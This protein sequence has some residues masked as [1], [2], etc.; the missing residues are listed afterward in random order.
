MNKSVRDILI[1]SSL[2]RT[3]EYDGNII[4]D[5]KV[6]ECI[7]DMYFYMLYFINNDSKKEEYFREFESKYQKL[8]KKQQEIVRDEYIDIIKTQKKNKE[9]V[10][11]KG[12]IN[13]E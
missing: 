4:I 3:S 5:E 11:K 7:M 6:S 1:A 10:K 13:Y 9:K 2:I 8:N 12:L